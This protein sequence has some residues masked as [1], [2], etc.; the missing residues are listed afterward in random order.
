MTPEKIERRPSSEERIEVLRDLFP[1][2][3]TDGR[4]AV[5]RLK[6]LLENGASDA[7]GPNEHYELSWNGKRR[8]QRLAHQTANTTL[9]SEPGA[10]VD[11][12]TTRNVVILGDNLHV[13]KSMQK[14]YAASV[15]LIYIDPPYNTGGDL[16]YKDD[17][18]QSAE[19]YL[20]ATGQS[21]R[22]WLSS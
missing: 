13:L 3:F 2:V 17:F 4:V 18:R 15:G 8:A 11:E 20:D 7:D 16:L 19:Q 14:S 5:E 21:N 10:G 22:E 1:E 6:E 9:R 12:A